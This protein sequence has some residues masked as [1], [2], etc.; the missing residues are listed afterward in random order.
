MSII[1]MENLFI[2][3]ILDYCYDNEILFFYEICDFCRSDERY[4]HWFCLLILHADFFNAYFDSL[5]K[6]SQEEKNQG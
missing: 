2:N 3:E 1:K 6:L 4:N 5:Y